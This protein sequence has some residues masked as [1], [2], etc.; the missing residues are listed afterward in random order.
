MTSRLD[1]T[2]RG[3]LDWGLEGLSQ[4]HKGTEIIKGG[5]VLTVDDSGDS[6]NVGLGMEGLSLRHEGT[7][8]KE[9]GL[10]L[11][12]DDSGDSGFHQFVTEV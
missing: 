1:L 12:V 11:T 4:R 10:E 7:E 2:I 8:I 9:G 5:L 3:L 6:G